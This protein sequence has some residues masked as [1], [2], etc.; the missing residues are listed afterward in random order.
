MQEDGE[1]RGEERDELGPLPG[2]H[3]GLSREQ[4][5]DSQRE[6]LLAAMAQEVA[7]QGYRATTITGVVKLAKVSTR[8]YYAHFDSKQDCF[9]AAFDAVA[10]HLTELISAAVA[11][12]SDWPHQV[13]A[14]LRAA[15][16]FFSA[17]PDLARLFLLEAAGAT[18]AIAIRFRQAVLAAVPPLALGR[19][20]LAD[21]A[22]LL[23]EAESSIIGGMVSLATRLIVSGEAEQLN[24]LLPDL[25]EFALSPYLGLDRA[26]ELA[27]AA[28]AA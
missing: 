19:E 6:R 14:A 22:S 18:P 9:L 23:P 5:L 25:A 12:E 24:E 27:R 4:I 20:E 16:G 11:A 1:R 8:D 13:I 17:N 10:D 2:G 15:L 28:Q 7:A 26:L 21:P 3:H